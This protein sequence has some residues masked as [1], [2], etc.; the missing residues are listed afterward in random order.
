MKTNISTPPPAGEVMD[1]AGAC[2]Y[3][4]TN[5]R[6]L[7]KMRQEYGLPFIRISTKC[8]RYRKS[9]LEQWLARRRVQ[10]AA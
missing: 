9:D 6:M 5:E 1:S 2:K 8:L 10:F 7:R 4:V 3:I